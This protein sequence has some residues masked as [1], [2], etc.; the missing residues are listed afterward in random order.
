[1]AADT[2]SPKSPRKGKLINL[3][4]KMLDDTQH[5]FQVQSKAMGSVLWESVIK[6]LELME[7]DY[8]DLE[9]YD[10]TNLQ[11]WLDREKPI[12]KQIPNT[13]VEFRFAVKFYTPDPGLL[14]EEYTRYLF[15]LQVKRDLK[16]EAL[17]CS[18][19][20]LALLA[21]YIVQAEIGDFLEDEYLDE[22]YL[23]LHKFVP[24]QSPDLDLKIMEYHRQHIGQGPSEADLNLLDTARKVE[25]YGIRNFPAKDHEG[26]HL[27]LSV[28][29][30][31]IVVFQNLTKINTFSWAKIRKL[32]FKRKKFLIKLHPENY[33]YYKDI[34]EFFFESRNECKGFWKK[35][36]EHHAFFRCHTVKKLPRNKTR[37]V[38]RGSSYR[39]SGKTQKQLM[40]YVREN[41]VKK[42]PF[43][44]KS[45]SGRNSR[46]TS[47]TPKSHQK[48]TT[49]NSSDFHVSQNSTASSGSH[50]LAENAQDNNC[51]TSSA[52]VETAEVHSE[53]SLSG[54]R[55]LNS[56]KLESARSHSQ[57][58]MATKHD[59]LE[60]DN[61]DEN[62]E[63]VGGSRTN[64]AQSIENAESSDHVP[65]RSVKSDFNDSFKNGDVRD[66]P[67]FAMDRKYSE[68]I[69]SKG[70]GVEENAII[71]SNEIEN[72]PEHIRETPEHTSSPHKHRYFLY[73][74]KSQW[75]LIR[76]MVAVGLAT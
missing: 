15:A 20:T 51:I 36:I 66:S 24:H 19:N 13:D 63:D 2:I 38:S 12:L 47:A 59:K 1:M 10:E 43:E 67:T 76:A 64:A 25:Q 42:R 34:V 17:P 41:Y 26:V 22:S 21:S 50:V 27:S 32:S 52:R 70:E 72:I 23:S 7:A 48:T 11:C 61:A 73:L 75:S 37:V 55:S 62:C 40:E 16:T 74:N 3:R 56:P 6:Y 9:Y 18:D 35:C 54:S 44:R 71:R 68:P 60:N 58:A 46:S 45:V 5:I 31:G 4:V 65:G 14:E 69:L 33:G 30:M 29:H 57:P 49:L 28:A 8:F 39:Y 53:S